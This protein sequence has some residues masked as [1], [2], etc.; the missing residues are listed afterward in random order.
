VGL[1][2]F[3]TWVG[4]MLSRHT[5][6]A[7]SSSPGAGKDAHGAHGKYLSRLLAHS[8]SGFFVESGVTIAG[9]WRGDGATV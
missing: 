2:F 6:L 9:D 7:G 8:T 4:S 5:N 1:M 3:C